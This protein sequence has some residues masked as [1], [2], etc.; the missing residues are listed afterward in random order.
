MSVDPTHRAWP[1]SGSWQN[2]SA[3][4]L[5]AHGPSW[6]FAKMDEFLGGDRQIVPTWPCLHDVKGKAKLH[7][8]RALATI[9]MARPIF[10]PQQRDSVIGGQFALERETGL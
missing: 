3:V 10:Q 8:C 6:R 1:Q 4:A 2:A 5:P 9:G 7:H